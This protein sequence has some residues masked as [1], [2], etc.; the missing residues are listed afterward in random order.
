MHYRLG[1]QVWC[2]RNLLL[3][4]RSAQEGGHSNHKRCH[5]PAAKLKSGF[6]PRAVNFPYRKPFLECLCIDCSS[7]CQLPETTTQST[8]TILIVDLNVRDI[9]VHPQRS[10]RCQQS[11]MRVADSF[12]HQQWSWLIADQTVSLHPQQFIP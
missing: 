9:S 3:V 4:A 2:A 12:P 10:R 6:G 11:I 8:L 1:I 7:H 5:T